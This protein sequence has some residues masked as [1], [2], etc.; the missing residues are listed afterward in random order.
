MNVLICTVGL[1]YSGKTT[2]AKG[3]GLPIVSPDAIR[4]AM[5]NCRFWDTGEPLVWAHTWIMCRTIFLA[6]HNEVILDVTNTTHKRRSACIRA[7]LPQDEKEITW[8]TVFHHIDTDRKVCLRR[9]SDANDDVIIP[10]I[11]KMADQFE[12]LD[13]S[14]VRWNDDY[15]STWDKAYETPTPGT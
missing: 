7:G 15:I 2:W 13:R 11:A 8:Q 4:L 14:E 6:G 3:Q 9:A 5:F 12:D 1:P 10:V